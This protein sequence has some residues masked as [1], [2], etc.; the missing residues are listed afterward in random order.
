MQDAKEGGDGV[1]GASVD[2]ASG[3]KCKG[4]DSARCKG[5]DGVKGESGAVLQLMQE[6]E[7]VV[8]EMEGPV[9]QDTNDH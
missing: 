7:K 5:G 1:K 6:H 2:G 3:A 4:G 8:Q 9:M